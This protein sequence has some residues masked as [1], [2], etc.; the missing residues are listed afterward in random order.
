M[1]GK[2]TDLLIEH[3]S[4]VTGVIGGTVIGK[5][6]EYSG[7]DTF[8]VTLGDTKTDYQPEEDYLQLGLPFDLP[9]PWLVEFVAGITS[10][11]NAG[12]SI[13]V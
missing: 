8:V 11:P 5:M 2:I 9:N 6:E 3:K 13:E 10:N 12:I 1:K 7:R 4:L